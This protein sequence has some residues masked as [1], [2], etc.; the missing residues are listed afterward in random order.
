MNILV[1]GACGFVMSALIRRLLM[2]DPE[3]QITAVDLSD[4]DSLL[5][6]ELTGATSRVSFHRVDLRDA[7]TLSDLVITTRPTVI[8]HA[9]TLTHVPSWERENPSRYLD[10][11]IGGT[12]NL[13]EAARQAPSVRR[14]VH[15]SSGAVYGAG[16]LTPN[17]VDEHSPLDAN[18]LYGITKMSTEAVVH[19]YGQLFDMTTPTVRLTKIFG[20]MERPTSARASMSLPFHLAASRISG[21]PVQLTPRTLT[22]GGD[23]LSSVDVSRALIPLCLDDSSPTGTWN[24]SGGRWTTV[25]ELLELFG[26]DTRSAEA[27]NDSTSGAGAGSVGGTVDID[28]EL[29]HG[30]DGVLSNTRAAI[31]LG[32]APRPLADQV[33]E[34]LEWASAHPRNFQ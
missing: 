24:L 8:V 9:A 33:D 20:E 10:V 30:K 25:P 11:N 28:P 21:V 2:T 17:P 7:D 14:L 29:T 3:V 27:Q 12:V 15:I 6:S 19:R 1:T 5:Q 31:D 18:E 26:T 16:E 34:Y 32:W 13:L 23:W 22:A 4:P